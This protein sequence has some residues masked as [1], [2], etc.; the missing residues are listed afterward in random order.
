MASVHMLITKELLDRPTSAIDVEPIDEELL[1]TPIFDLNIAKLPPSTNASTL[2]PPAATAD[3]MATATQITNFLKLMLDEILTLALVRMD[4]S[5][6][7][8]PTAM[9]AETGTTTD[10]TLM[11]IPEESTIDQSKSM[12]VVPAE[13]AMMLPPM[14]PTVDRRIYLAT[15]AILP[16]SPIIATVAAASK[17]ASKRTTHRCQQRN[18]QKARQETSQTRSQTSV[19]PQPKVTTTKAAAPAKQTPPACRSESHHSH[20]ES[21]SRDDG[22][23]KE[24]QQLPTTSPDSHQHEGHNNAP[25]HCTQREQVPQVHSTGFYKDTYKHGFS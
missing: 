14:A 2:P 25:P 24:T 13:P 11:D 23:R 5:T 16:G 12:D 18:Q 9:D 15:P 10:Q 20:Q 21:H 4:K 7:V 3:L 22:H 6:P 8:Q 17:T 1:D 19:T